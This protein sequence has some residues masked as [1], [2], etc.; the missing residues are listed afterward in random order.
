[1][2]T[3][4]EPATSPQLPAE[5]RDAI[6]RT[7]YDHDVYIENG[8]RKGIEADVCA[9]VAPFFAG[10]LTNEEAKATRDFVE[11]QFSVPQPSA[12]VEK[13]AEEIAC[14]L[15]S[16]GDGKH[17]ERLVFSLC[18][19]IE[20]GGWSEHAMKNHI[21]KF[22]HRLVAAKDAEIVKWQGLSE[23]AEAE[24]HELR[25]YVETQQKPSWERIQQA[26]GGDARP[27]N[28]DKS[29]CDEV[30]DAIAERDVLKAEVERLTR[31]DLKHNNRALNA[32]ETLATAEQHVAALREALDKAEAIL[33]ALSRLCDGTDEAQKAFVAW[34]YCRNA[35]ETTAPKNH[36]SS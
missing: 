23:R 26:L 1:M 10:Q 19:G 25:Y 32:E 7:L 27:L 13:V 35:R 17:A 30:V 9:A 22:L 21:A 15:F 3:E 28:E 2:S 6:S 18:G 16:S 14:A 24:L 4:Q 11:A 8:K 31:E 5:A 20:W 36:S 34:K 33:P 29:L 12:D